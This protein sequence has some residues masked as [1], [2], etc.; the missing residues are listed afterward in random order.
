MPAVKT[1]ILPAISLLLV[2]CL[3]MVSIQPQRAV[4]LQTAGPG[5]ADTLFSH[6]IGN[7]LASVFTLDSRTSLSSLHVL[8]KDTWISG[9]VPLNFY[10]ECSPFSKEFIADFAHR[11]DRSTSPIRAPPEPSQSH[12]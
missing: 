10:R 11:A 6:A 9:P 2:F 8:F 4:G 12:S 1:K 3:L 7:E 5:H